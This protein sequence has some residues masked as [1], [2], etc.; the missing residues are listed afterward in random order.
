MAAFGVP[1]LFPIFTKFIKTQ[2]PLPLALTVAASFFAK[3]DRADGRTAKPKKRY[4]AA[5]NVH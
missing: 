3:K 2:P 4:I 1:L 5:V